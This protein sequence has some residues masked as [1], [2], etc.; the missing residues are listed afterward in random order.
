MFARK[1]ISR[2]DSGEF[3]SKT[4]SVGLLQTVRAF[5]CG[6]SREEILVFALPFKDD[7]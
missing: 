2:K 3:C 1:L 5:V 7:T 4:L 6:M